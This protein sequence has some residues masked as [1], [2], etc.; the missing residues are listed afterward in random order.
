M[1]TLQGV[2]KMKKLAF[3]T[4]MMA[5]MN[6]MGQD[7][8]FSQY[9][10]APLHL[11]PGLVGINQNARFGV[12]YRNQWP[13]FDANGET[14]SS[15]FDYNFDEYHSSLGLMFSAT[16]EGI[17][18][19]TNTSIALQYA[20][21]VQV[22]YKWVLRSGMEFSYSFRGLNEDKAIWGD[23][24]GE[25][26]PE[27]PTMEDLGGLLRVDDF[28][29]N[30]PDIAI[31]GVL[32]SRNIWIGVARHHLLTPNVSFLNDQTAEIQRKTTIHGGIKLPLRIWRYVGKNSMGLE[33]SFSPTFHYRAQKDFHQ[34]DLGAYL[35]LA[36][37]NVGFWYRGILINSNNLRERSG[38]RVSPE[39]L[40]FMGSLEQNNTTFGYSYDFSLSQLAPGSGGAH[41][42]SIVHTFKLGNKRKP[43]KN[44]RKLRCPAPGMIF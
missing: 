22:D 21:E 17:T 10:A 16:R 4:L 27:R 26:G 37:V 9:Y 8:H 35:T 30:Y 32:F 11:N 40:I 7:V 43:A 12:N 18:A 39:S 2:M 5:S 33:R 25:Y 34:L 28:R 15:Y 38:Q 44:K 6:V 24:L 42:V 36:P 3:L 20:Y 23:Q 31:G 13:G 1:G 14:F 29:L 41:E 19:L